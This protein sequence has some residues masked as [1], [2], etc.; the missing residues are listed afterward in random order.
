LKQQTQ[1][2]IKEC[3]RPSSPRKVTVRQQKKPNK[4]K[5]NEKS[6]KTAADERENSP[7]QP[8][9]HVERRPCQV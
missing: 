2:E 6:S 5:T 7:K 3:V 9:G 1:Q 8:Y 4:A